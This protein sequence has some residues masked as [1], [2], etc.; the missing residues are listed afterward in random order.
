MTEPT[1]TGVFA[2]D[3]PAHQT[4][5]PLITEDSSTQNAHNHVA[6]NMYQ[7]RD[8]VAG[9]SESMQDMNKVSL[10]ASLCGAVLM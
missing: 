4:S 5:A 8:F 10:G 9:I 6:S 2:F 1:T 7:A 3:V